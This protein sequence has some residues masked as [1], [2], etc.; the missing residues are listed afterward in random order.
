MDQRRRLAAEAVDERVLAV[1]RESLAAAE[2]VRAAKVAATTERRLARSRLLADQKLELDE[3]AA[4]YESRRQSD[5]S[6]M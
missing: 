1:A 3:R 4:R 2:A 5:T 6:C